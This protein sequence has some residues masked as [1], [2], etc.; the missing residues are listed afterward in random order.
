MPDRVNPHSIVVRDM[1]STNGIFQQ[2]LDARQVS[3]WERINGSATLG[4]GKRFRIGKGVAEI[5]VR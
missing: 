3:R 2:V 4:P 1:Q 5:E